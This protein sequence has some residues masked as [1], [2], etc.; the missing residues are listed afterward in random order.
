MKNYAPEL[1]LVLMETTLDES[2]TPH[3]SI[4]YDSFTFVS[5]NRLIEK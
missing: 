4:V 5:P 2:G 1:G 3:G